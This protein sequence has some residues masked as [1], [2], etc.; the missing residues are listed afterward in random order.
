LLYLVRTFNFHGTVTIYSD[1]ALNAAY[2]TLSP[3]LVRDDSKL[4]NIVLFH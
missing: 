4:L 1:V 3:C 2:I